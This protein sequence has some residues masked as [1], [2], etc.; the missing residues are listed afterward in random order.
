MVIQATVKF[1]P[2]TDFEMED[3]KIPI[4]V[5]VVLQREKF[6]FSSKQVIS[7]LSEWDEITQR[8]KSIKSPVNK[9]LSE[10]ENKVQEAFN[11]L[12]YHSL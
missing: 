7:K 1:F 4:Y 6:D 3:N 11:F 9:E 5:R 10:I 8:V 2:R 12:K